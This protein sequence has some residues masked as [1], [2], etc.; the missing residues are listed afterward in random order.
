MGSFIRR[1]KVLS[2]I[3][4]LSKQEGVSA[5]N[6]TKELFKEYTSSERAKV[7]SLLEVA[8]KNLD[9]TRVTLRASLQTEQHLQEVKKNQRTE[10]N[11]DELFNNGKKR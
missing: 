4:R 7:R 6:V 2:A 9:E 5:Y 8:V 11:K 3:K 10:T 1:Q